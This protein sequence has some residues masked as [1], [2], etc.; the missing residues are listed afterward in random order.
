MGR[1]G[2]SGGR[3]PDGPHRSSSW[4]ETTR[5][6]S[7][8]TPTSTSRC[9]PSPSAPWARPASAARRS[10]G[11]SWRSRRQASSPR[12][13][14]GLPLAGSKDRRSA[15]TGHA[16]RPAHRCGRGGRLPVR[17]GPDQGRRRRGPGWRKRRRSVQTSRALPRRVFRGAHAG[18]GPRDLPIAR[19]ETFAPSSTCS[20]PA[21]WTRRWRSRTASPQGLS[22]AVFTRVAARRRAFPER[23]RE[24]LR[25][26][27][28]EHRTE[29]GGDRGRV[30][31]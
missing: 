24:R 30:R 28:R 16:G 23:R 13:G 26:R 12:A 21:G 27:Q 6:S 1:A 4:G 3:A 5:R 20:P 14:Q 15:G 10:G 25:H 8:P 29:R 18:A 2:R 11:S 17:P 19:E 31:R 7:S 9:A 22:S